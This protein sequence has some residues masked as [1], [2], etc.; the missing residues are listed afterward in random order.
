M[1]TGLEALQ[2]GLKALGFDGLIGDDECGCDGSIPCGCDPM[3]CECGYL[4]KHFPYNCDSWYSN[5]PCTG[6][7]CEICGQWKPEDEDAD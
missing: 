3:G 5:V 6:D 7:D 2:A 4:H 1:T